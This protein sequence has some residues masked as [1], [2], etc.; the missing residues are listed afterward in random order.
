MGQ[1]RDAPNENPSKIRQLTTDGCEILDISI[2][3]SGRHVGRCY[4]AELARIR[5]PLF[6]G[7]AGA[8]AAT[9]TYTD[10][11]PE[12]LFMGVNLPSRER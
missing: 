4:R 11:L 9:L 5:S 1:Q 6:Y 7:P 2:G 10:Q 8:T 3:G 12:R